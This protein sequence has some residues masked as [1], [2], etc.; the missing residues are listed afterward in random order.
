MTASAESV[1]MKVEILAMEARNLFSL[2]KFGKEKPSPAVISSAF[3]SNEQ[4]VCH[5][6]RIG[7]L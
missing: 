2:T 5:D 7:R 4:V 1:V 3:E 6:S